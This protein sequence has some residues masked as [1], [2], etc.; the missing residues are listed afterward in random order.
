MLIVIIIGPGLI[1]LR[2]AWPAAGAMT[3]EVNPAIVVLG[4]EAVITFLSILRRVRNITITL[5]SDYAVLTR[6]ETPYVGRR[7]IL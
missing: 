3:E 5:P 4:N 7:A 6:R 1:S 2:T